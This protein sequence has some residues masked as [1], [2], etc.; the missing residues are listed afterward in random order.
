[1][2]VIIINNNNFC[3]VG[4]DRL[5]F[6]KAGTSAK[7]FGMCYCILDTI[8]AQAYYS[9]VSPIELNSAFSQVNVHG[10]VASEMFHI[11][12]P[13]ETRKAFRKGEEVL[14]WQWEVLFPEHASLNTFQ[15]KGRIRRFPY[16][17]YY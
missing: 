13:H 9:E 5:L 3:L 17:D 8:A 12:Q 7:L 16:K 4:H 15:I 11:E 10:A 1:M 2:L 14:N 6:L